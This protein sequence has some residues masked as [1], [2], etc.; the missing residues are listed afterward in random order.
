MECPSHTDCVN[1]FLECSQNIFSQVAGLRAPGS[2][3]KVREDFRERLLEAF[4]DLE[5]KAFERQI[6]M[7]ML[8]DAKYALAAYVDEAVLG[9]DWPG[10]EAWMGRPLQLEMFGDHVAGEGFFERLVHLRQGGEANLDVIELY[11]VCLQLGFEGIY[12]VRG[13]EQLMAL[14]VDLRSQIEGYRGVTDPRLAPQGVSRE[15]ILSRVRRE[16]PY[17]V[18]GV[19]TVSILFFGYIGYAYTI[20]RMAAHSLVQMDAQGRSLTRLAWENRPAAAERAE[21]K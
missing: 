21:V 1:P 19:V 16:V 9:S 8:K 5:R 7:V 4:D 15:G 12:K 10:R 18:I 17:W 13:L 11:Y 20:H 6:P 3:V 14:Q 2:S